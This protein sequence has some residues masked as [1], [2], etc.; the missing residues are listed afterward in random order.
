M[1]YVSGGTEKGTLEPMMQIDA[2]G[3][4]YKALNDRI[5]RAVE[6]GE[7]DFRIAGVNGQ[8]YIAGGIKGKDISFVI[9]GV[10]GNDLAVFM[11]GPVV[12]VM[13]NA[14][15]AI[16][17]TMNEGKIV[18]HGDAGD[19]IGYGMRGGRIHVLGDVGYRVG[20]HMKEYKDKVPVI[21]IGGRAHDFFGEYM[22]G[23][24]QIILGLNGING[25]PIA[26]HFT[27]TGMHGGVIYLRGKLEDVT[28]AKEVELYRVEDKD[29]KL[30]KSLLRDYC[31]DF[32]LDLGEIL[33]G[34]FIKLAPQSSRPYSSHYAY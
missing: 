7:R 12:K 13:N 10:P 30:L 22:A 26:G 16:G 21:I 28:L 32:N 24:V 19:I 8:R 5:R 27:A 2:K 23:G 20:I 14:E 1:R 18:I 17:N 6:D 9:E 33:N 34:E 25:R 31:R 29:K 3:M 15:D 11:D 4:Y